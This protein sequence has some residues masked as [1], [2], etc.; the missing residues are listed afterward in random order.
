MSDDER[1]AVSGYGEVMIGRDNERKGS[2]EI[3]RKGDY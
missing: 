1:K 2:Q 3:E